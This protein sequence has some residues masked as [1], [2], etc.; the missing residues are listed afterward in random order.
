MESVSGV[1]VDS[2]G[3][4]GMLMPAH[5]S[6]IICEVQQLPRIRFWALKEELEDAFARDK[7]NVSNSCKI[8]DV[9]QQRW[10]LSLC[11]G[12]DRGW[13]TRLP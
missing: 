4:A 9:P 7:L 12:L 13:K 2:P 5:P 1:P 3:A 8:R 6:G 11:P 10:R